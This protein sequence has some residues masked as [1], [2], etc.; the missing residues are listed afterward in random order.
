MSA[1]L[2]VLGAG[3]AG[4]GAAY[5]AARAGHR[6][7][8]VE[9][10]AVAGGAA[11]KLRARRDPRRLRQPSPSPLDRRPDPRGPAQPARR[12]ARASPTTSAASCSRGGGSPF[13]RGRWPPL[14]HLPPSFVLGLAGDA[15]TAWARRPRDDTF[16]EV[17]RAGL[18]PTMCE[19][20]YFPYARKIW[21]VEPEQL[22]GE[23]ARRRV[24]AAID[25]LRWLRARFCC[26]YATGA[27]FWYPSSRLRHDQRAA[28]RRGSRRRARHCASGSAVEALDTSEDRVVATLSDGTTIAAGR[29]FTTLPLGTLA[30][31]VRPRPPAAVRDAVAALRTRALLLVY[32][33]FALRPVHAVRRALHTGR[34][35]PGDPDLGA[36]ELPRRRRPRG[37]HR[38]VRGDSLSAGST[39]SG[40]PPKTRQPGLVSRDARTSRA[41]GS[42]WR[43][44]SSKASSRRLP[45]LRP[46]L[47]RGLRRGRRLAAGASAAAHVRSPGPLRS[48]QHAS[49]ARNGLGRNRRA[50]ERTASFDRPLEAARS[51]SRPTWSRRPTDPSGRRLTRCAGH[52]GVGPSARRSAPGRRPGR[53]RAGTARGA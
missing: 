6:V 5:R 51:A 46:R 52:G 40:A 30:Q 38:S 13:L 21:G 11:G 12:R 49:R 4:A 41:S 32:L 23:Q 15:A 44:T 29:A 26:F 14:S 7:V 50:R 35:T 10:A 37:P 20:F 31:L 19:R 53:P 22:D 2:L 48:R 24:S 34:V 36:E 18:G 42:R 39:P 43:A 1:D 16:A 8:L 9:R 33:V 27:S 47:E 3:P 28:G 17:L 45:D 25:R